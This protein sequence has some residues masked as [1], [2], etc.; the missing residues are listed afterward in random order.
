MSCLESSSLLQIMWYNSRDAKG[1]GGG[2]GSGLIG[3]VKAFDTSSCRWRGVRSKNKILMSRSS[4]NF[5]SS[6]ATPPFHKMHL[7][8]K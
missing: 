6:K 2:G 4:M 5:P 3:S 1:G 7:L 8:S